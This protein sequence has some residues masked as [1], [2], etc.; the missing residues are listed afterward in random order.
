M[1]YPILLL[2]SGI[3]CIFS[4]GN[5]HIA[6]D[7]PKYNPAMYFIRDSI[8]LFREA[9][10]GDEPDV[11]LRLEDSSSLRYDDKNHL[12]YSYDIDKNRSY[13]MVYTFRK[14]K[15]REMCFDAILQDTSEAD[16]LLNAFSD[17]YTARYGKYSEVMGFRVWSFTDTSQSNCIFIEL[18]DESLEFGYPKLNLTFYSKEG[19][20]P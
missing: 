1:K 10:M 4:C 16:G 11:I 7:K 14:N 2:L 18:N 5:Q 3:I 12:I 8:G 13:S 17:Y 9:E 20:C 15:L 6:N 19:T